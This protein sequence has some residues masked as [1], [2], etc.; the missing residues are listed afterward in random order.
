MRSFVRPAAATAI[1]AVLAAGCGSPPLTRPAPVVSGVAMVEPAVSARPVGAADTAFGLSV[2]GAWCKQQPDS[3]LVISPASLASGLG[4]AYLGARG[5]T[6]SVMARVLR[7]PASGSALLAMLAAR[8]AALRRLDRPGVTVAAADQIWANPKLPARRAYLNAIA[9][10]YHAGLGKVPLLTDPG[11]AARQID[12][13]IARATHGHITNLL[14][15]GQLQGIGWVLTDALYLNARWRTPFS[16]AQTVTARFTTASG[17]SVQA[18]Y[19]TGDLRTA[20]VPGWTAVSVP[21]RGGALAMEALLPNSGT[22]GCPA[23]SAAD[24]RDATAALSRPGGSPSAMV[25]TRLPKVNLSSKANMLQLLTRLG[26]GQ[27]FSGDANFTGLSKQ[28]AA[29]GAV[30]HAATLQVAERGTVASAATAVG[31]L[32]SAAMAPPKLIFD[33]P[34]LLV[35]TD[36]ATGEPLFMARVADPAQR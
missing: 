9:T 27:A 15:S 26:M 23:L 34:Y 8:S 32:P 30:V 6:A 16:P 4:M 25:M 22:R 24:L 36:L 31:I 20:T 21:Y 35:I 13:S 17:S 3:N 11:Q 19:L 29:I 14:N 7:L 18:R 12:A 10:G 1:A 5:R 28:A 2:L 33:R